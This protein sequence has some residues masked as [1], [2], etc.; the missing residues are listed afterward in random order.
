MYYKMIKNKKGLLKYLFTI[1]YILCIYDYIDIRKYVIGL[2]LLSLNGF[3]TYH[4]KSI[5]NM[6][7]YQEY[8]GQIECYNILLSFYMRDKY[9]KIISELSL[10]F[11]DI[12]NIFSNKKN[13][14]FN[15][16]IEILKLI[17]YK[18]HIL[19]SFRKID[20]NLDNNYYLYEAIKKDIL[21]RLHLILNHY[22]IVQLKFLN[23]PLELY[24][25]LKIMNYDNLHKY[26]FNTINMIEIKLINI[27]EECSIYLT[28][29]YQ[30]G[31]LLNR[32]IDR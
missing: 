24:S 12:G 29:E 22:T 6:I 27:I 18:L 13:N 11:P 30:H 10:I 31:I 25:N 17:V 26:Y 20:K 2:N 7:I 21:Y 9:Y 1:Y 15:R 16:I 28:I 23:I 19:K 8:I 14:I 4:I 5:E 32:W 3:K